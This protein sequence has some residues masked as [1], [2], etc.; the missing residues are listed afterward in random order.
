MNRSN[1]DPFGIVLKGF[2]TEQVFSMHRLVQ[3]V[4]LDTM[5]DG[6]QEKWSARVIEAL[7]VALPRSV[8][9]DRVCRLEAM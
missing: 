8:A 2:R 6:E 9:C 7:D 4:L 5:T 3:A 1:F